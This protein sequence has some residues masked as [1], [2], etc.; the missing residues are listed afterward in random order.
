MNWKS[1]IGGAFSALGSALMGIGIVPQLAGTTSKTLTYVAMAGFISNAIG[2]F[3]GHLF[4]ADAATVKTLATQVDANTTALKTG[5][6]S[7]LDK[8]KT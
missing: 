3:L 2:S 4:S 1:T 6:T 5:D 7:I 8:P